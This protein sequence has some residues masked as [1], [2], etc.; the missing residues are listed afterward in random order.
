M[1]AASLTK[2]Y[3]GNPP[4]GRSVSPPTDRPVFSWPGASARQGEGPG[5][6]ANRMRDPYGDAC[7]ARTGGPYAVPVQ[8]RMWRPYRGAR[9]ARARASG[10]PR[11]AAVRPAGAATP[12]F[13]DPRP[14]RGT[15]RL[16]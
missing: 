7:G 12:D 2:G 11:A 14:G 3:G 4:S 16:R 1:Y 13:G 10:E 6:R 5:R 8:G 9:G 15:L